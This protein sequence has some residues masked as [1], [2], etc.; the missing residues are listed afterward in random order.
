MNSPLKLSVHLLEVQRN[1]PPTDFDDKFD[2]ESVNEAKRD[3]H[4]DANEENGL[5]DGRHDEVN[6][7]GAGEGD[8][9]FAE[10]PQ[11][12]SKRNSHDRCH[13]TLKL[14]HDFDGERHTA[15]GMLVTDVPE[16]QFHTSS[17][18]TDQ[19][20]NISDWKAAYPYLEIVDQVGDGDSCQ[21]ESVSL[22]VWGHSKLA[23]QLRQNTVDLISKKWDTVGVFM[24][25]E[26]AGQMGRTADQLSKNECLAHMRSKDERGR[27]LWGNSVTLHCLP[28][29]IGK[30]IVV[31]GLSSGAAFKH[32][33]KA[34][35]SSDVVYIGFLPEVHFFGCRP[36]EKRGSPQIGS[37]GF[38]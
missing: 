2:E 14:D 23:E 26:V 35:R 19:K 7:E 31:L 8:G 38:F 16:R 3:Q 13:H 12:L 25:G 24:L 37:K 6:V 29:I 10:H 36:A 5:N 9:R 17:A 11:D 27:Y 33:L 30:T 4:E 1:I 15:I 20:V 34:E 28:E 32:T 22:A 21:F 18:T